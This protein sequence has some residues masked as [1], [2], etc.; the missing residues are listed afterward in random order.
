[1]LSKPLLPVALE[2]LRLAL[3][4]ALMGSIIGVFLGVTL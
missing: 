3:M 2:I 1:M 4:G